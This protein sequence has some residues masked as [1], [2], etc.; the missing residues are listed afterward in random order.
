MSPKV[1]INFEQFIEEINK[2]NSDS[3]VRFLSKYFSSNFDE[4]K[5]PKDRPWDLTPSNLMDLSR[6]LINYSS[7]DSEINI[8]AEKIKFLLK[9]YYKLKDATNKK[10]LQS[11]KSLDN[12]GKIILVFVGSINTVASVIFSISNIRFCRY[13]TILL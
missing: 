4:W 3:I 8:S 1:S 13:E 6:F 12:G 10:L 7:I 11:E 9:E 2:Y 5:K